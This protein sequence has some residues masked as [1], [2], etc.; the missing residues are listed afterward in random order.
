MEKFDAGI[1]YLLMEYLNIKNF[2]DLCST[3]KQLYR[4]NN[5]YGLIDK[6][7]EMIMN[8]RISQGFETAYTLVSTN[9]NEIKLGFNEKIIYDWEPQNE[10]DPMISFSL[11][12]LYPRYPF[13]ER[14]KKPKWVFGNLLVHDHHQ[15]SFNISVFDSI[16][17]IYDEFMNAV[18]LKSISCPIIEFYEN[19]DGDLSDFSNISYQWRMLK[20]NIENDKNT[21][22][23][24]SVI[25]RLNKY[26]E[27]VVNA[28]KRI[29][30]PEGWLSEFFC[31]KIK[32]EYDKP[33]YKEL[34]F[35]TVYTLKSIYSS[36][37]IFG[38]KN[39]ITSHKD[40]DLIEYSCNFS[41]KGIPLPTGTKKVIFGYCDVQHKSQRLGTYIDKRMHVY[42]SF[43]QLCQTF[44]EVLTGD[45]TN[46]VFN[47]F[48][49]QYDINIGDEIDEEGIIYDNLN[50]ANNKWI[51][52]YNSQKYK[53]N[54][55]QLKFEDCKHF[56]EYDLKNIQ[57][58]DCFN[59]LIDTFFILVSAGNMSFEYLDVIYF[60]NEIELP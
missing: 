30:V 12:G 20:N 13:V 35:E 39:I 40:K 41:I 11:P 60:C 6:K 44:V 19:I 55:K 54:I 34:G 32:F 46:E 42:D 48:I 14:E 18:R 28:K 22:I 45:L 56:V 36:E 59:S 51:I 38:L 21:Y 57:D 8:R 16:E 47:N 33:I 49:G 2:V 1:L 10:H 5:I 9:S 3:C 58:Q 17:Q 27:R 24:S 26:M 23:D 7:V 50:I 43:Y 15:S 29:S 31:Y 25:E 4:L 52:N 37:V 53:N